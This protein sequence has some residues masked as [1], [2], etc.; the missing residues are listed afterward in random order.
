MSS[1]IAVRSEPNLP[2]AMESA[3]DE[4]REIAERWHDRLT[5]ERHSIAENYADGR[6]SLIC[7]LNILAPDAR[8]DRNAR[9]NQC[10]FN[11]GEVFAS[12]VFAVDRPN[13]RNILFRDQEPVLVFDIKSVQTP[14]GIPF[15]PL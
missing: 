5:V 15:P 10:P 2:Q 8:V 4:M 3:A 6:V 14:E 13:V 1:Q 12:S 11:D 7:D 9:V